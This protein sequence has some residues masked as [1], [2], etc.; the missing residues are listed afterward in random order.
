MQ[1]ISSSRITTQPNLNFHNQLK[2]GKDIQIIGGQDLKTPIA[3]QDNQSQQF[4]INLNSGN[5]SN[6]IISQ[7]NKD[8]SSSL[9]MG[10]G[11]VNIRNI[12]VNNS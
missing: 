3:I 1:R 6:Q 8:N 7:D 12:K 4:K 10:S 5:S 2:T 9:K 11:Q